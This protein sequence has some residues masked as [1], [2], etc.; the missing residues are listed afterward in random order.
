M[1]FIAFFSINIVRV[2]KYAILVRVL[3]SW[4]A[5]HGGGGK[6]TEVIHEI[7]E[8]I[9]RV[10]RNIIPPIAMIDFSPIL[11]FFA[12]DLLESGLT[13]FFAWLKKPFY[14]VFHGF[15]S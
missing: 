10:F 8:P 7:T 15:L 11:A 12:L 4:V 13:S 1:E 14:V 3:L 6:I 9:M 5:P 2:I